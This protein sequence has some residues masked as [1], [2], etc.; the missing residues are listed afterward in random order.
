MLAAA[1]A[2]A[3]RTGAVPTALTFDPHP[4]VLLAPSRVPLLLSSLD[5]RVALL[6]SAG[7]AQVI[8]EPFDARLGALTPAEFAERVLV[9]RLRASTVVVGDDFRFGCHRSGDIATLKEL[10]ARLGFTVRVIPPVLV[11]GV[12]ARSSVVRQMVADSRVEAAARLLGRPLT[13]SGTVVRGR[14]LGRTI[15]FP[16]AN[17]EVPAGLSVPGAGVYAGRAF[18]PQG[19]FAAA[20]SVGVNVTVD[21][22]APSTVEAYLLDFD[23]DL[24]DRPLTLEFVAHLRGM[25]KFDGLAALSAQIAQDVAATRRAILL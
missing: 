18:V 25:V 17:L 20:I 16:T 12:P 13:R 15:G 1:V 6:Q 24:Y 10:G 4:A 14:Q 2:E 5:E 21:E 19:V 22:T 23:D 3:G 9:G 7:A 11:D 8:V